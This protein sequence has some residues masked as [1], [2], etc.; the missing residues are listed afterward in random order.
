MKD[1]STS[2]Q[3]TEGGTIISTAQL[4]LKIITEIAELGIS[5]L[6]LYQDCLNVA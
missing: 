5:V 4:V 1:L 3:K 2:G 6:A